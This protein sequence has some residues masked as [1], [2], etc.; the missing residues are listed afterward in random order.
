[1]AK[2]PGMDR[3]TFLSRAGVSIGAFPFI[4]SNRSLGGQAAPSNRFAFASIGIGGMGGGN[5]GGF[6]N[7]ENVQIVAVCD[8]D[9]SRCSAAQKRVNKHYAGKTASGA[10][11]GCDAYSDFREIIARDD[12][13]GV[14]IS[15]P[16]HWHVPIAVAAAKSGKDMYCEK[17]L[18]LTVGEGRVL[19]DT[20]RRYG[21]VLQVGSQQRSGRNFRFACELVRNGRIGKL[22]RIY[23]N[24][25]GAPS[26][27]VHVPMDVPGGFDYDMWL[28]SAPWAPY[29]KARCHGSFRWIFDYSGGKMT[30]WGAHHNDIAQWANGA[31]RSG[32]VAVEGT[33]RFPSDG[34]YNVPTQFEVTYT[35]ANDV[36][37]TCRSTGE[38]GIRFEGSD[39][40][41]FVSRSRIDGHPKSLLRETIA[42]DEIHLYESRDHRANL[43]ECMAT[44]R[45]TVAPAEVGH[46]SATVCHIGNIAM[47]LGRKLKWD[48]DR[49]RFAGDEVANRMLDRS[50]RSP[51]RL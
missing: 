10:Y 33:G 29:T 7:R 50:R 43:L 25:G 4:L 24:I 12:I 3:R 19:S 45:E 6:M 37:L 2:S 20:I 38:N 48:P 32:P 42:P 21:R 8:A 14:I 31:D 23:A 5:L 39:G 15:T 16:D 28:G 26:T 34:L 30:D 9:G 1:M 47:I 51:W 35:Y 13:D 18:T 41:I 17:P 46:R 40:W 27:G 11:K 22:E 36:V 44:R 49:E